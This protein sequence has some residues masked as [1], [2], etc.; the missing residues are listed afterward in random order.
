MLDRWEA[1]SSKNT[2]TTYITNNQFYDNSAVGA[3]GSIYSLYLN[4]VL[5]ERNEFNSVRIFF[6]FSF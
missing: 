1:D 6:E 2:N 5:M 3:G 4:D